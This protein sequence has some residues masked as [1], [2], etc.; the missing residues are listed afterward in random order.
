M[1]SE[2]TRIF[3]PPGCALEWDWHPLIK[4][5]WGSF[6]KRT[7]MYE[8]PLNISINE[9]GEMIESAL[10]KPCY[11]CGITLTLHN[12]SPDHRRPL[13]YGGLSEPSNV[14]IIC[15]SCNLRKGQHLESRFHY[16]KNN[17]RDRLSRGLPA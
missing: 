6:Q 11:H 4:K 9:L 2:I 12:F 13:F 5:A 10:N 3:C 7:L 16:H 8:R 17:V 15:V 14:R 1:T